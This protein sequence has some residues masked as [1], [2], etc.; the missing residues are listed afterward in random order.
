M[1]PIGG[2]PAH[3]K[4]P[5]TA[6]VVSVR[7]PL[8]YRF[9]FKLGEYDTDIQHG[10]PHRGRGI[11]L[12]R[13]GNK[14][15][16][17]LLEQF[18]HVGKVQNGTADTVKFVDNDLCDQAPLNVPHQLLKHGAVSVLAAVSLVCVFFAATAF[19]LVFAKFNLAFNG[20]AVLFV[21]RLSCIDCVYPII[22]SSLLFLK[23]K[24]SC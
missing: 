10:P 20:N 16:I 21:H 24:R 23:K 2:F 6:G 7:H 14:L 17:V 8:L 22:H 3:L 4:A 12:F 13:R 19:Q 1:E 5:L 9:P 11:K 18:H 15:H